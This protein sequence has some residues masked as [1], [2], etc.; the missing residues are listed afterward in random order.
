MRAGVVV[1]VDL[2]FRQCKLHKGYRKSNTAVD[3]V[4]GTR[5]TMMRQTRA[6]VAK[7]FPHHV[8]I[9]ALLCNPYLLER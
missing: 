7:A 3:Q 6:L 4:A 8:A 9:D 1:S 5:I 2:S